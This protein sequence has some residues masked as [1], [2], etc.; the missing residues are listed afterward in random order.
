MTSLE[1]PTV[2]A[3]DADA[4]AALLVEHYDLRGTLSPLPGERDQNFRVVDAAGQGWVAKVALPDEESAFVMQAALLAHVAAVDPTL[5]IPRLRPSQHGQAI[6]PIAH[7]GRSYRLRVVSWLEGT[8]L[9]ESPRSH[10]QLRA[11]GRTA[12]RLA[13][14][15]RSFGHP[16]AHR[17]LDWDIARTLLSRPR[18]AHVEDPDRRA[19]LARALDDFEVRVTPRLPALRHSVVH[20][21]LNDWNVLV[22]GGDSDR[23]S[24]LIDLGDTVFS[25]TAADVAIACAYAMLDVPSPLIAAREVIGGFHDRMPLEE[26][27]LE[28]MLDLI[29][30][31]LATSLC[32]SATRRVLAS[33]GNSYWF[34]SERPAWTL[35][36]RLDR[37]NRHH[38]L[39]L[40]RHACGLEPAR[41]SAAIQRWIARSTARFA[42]ILD[43]PL[44]RRAT[45]RLDWSDPTDPVVA[46]TVRGDTA[47]ADAAYNAAA[48][49]GGF[50]VGVGAWC[51]ERA[52]Y[53]ADAFASKLIEGA[54]RTLHLGLDVFVDAGANLRTPLDGRV[55]VAADC[56][57][58]QD[59]GG[60]LLLEHVTDDGATFRTLWGHLAP[61]SIAHWKPGDVV[62]AG[63]VVARLGAS[64]ENGGWV[65]HLHL[66]L[67]CSGEHEAEAIIGVG[68]PEL[69]A[70]WESLYP[71]PTGLAGLPPEALATHVP[72]TQS[73]LERRRSH[74]GANLSL[75]YRRPLHI[76]RGTDVW[77]VDA[78]GRHYLDGYNNV[79]HVGHC[80]PRVVD[81]VARQAAQ[82]NTNTRYLHEHILTYA[83]RIA[84]TLPAPLGVC[85]FTCSGSEANELALRLARAHTR[86]RDVLV[87]DWAYHGSTTSLVEI[88]PYKYKHRGGEGRAA[89]VHEVPVPDPYRA[90]AD[91]PVEEI[92]T[93]YAQSVQATLSGGVAPAAFFAETIPSCAGQVFIPPGFLAE[94]YAAVRATGGVC[95]ADEV[96]VGFGRVGESMWAFAE[97]GVVPDIVTLGKPI[98]NGHPMG[99]VVTTPDIA[100]SFANG[101]EYFNTFG[102]NPVSC[103]AG[104]AVLDV[105]HDQALLP[106]AKKQGQ[107]I[108]AGLHDLMHRHEVIGDVRGRGLFIGVELVTDRTSKAPATRVAADVVNR[109]RDLGVLLGTDGPHDNVLKIRPPMTV[110]G[111][112]VQ[113]LL[114]TLG[115][116]LAAAG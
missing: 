62:R 50:D 63:D 27:E 32:M 79:A 18:L 9:A 34:V 54:R 20:G 70:L 93:R 106:N 53:S 90:P 45:Q 40:F 49:A 83:E 105:L 58:P 97:H 25:I 42:P 65:P 110:D 1:A 39:A 82:L 41:G 52:I 115:A 109:C 101:L 99:A 60:V 77:L 33:E 91:W 48:A 111:A 98:G 35:L 107:A 10:E 2:P 47:A 76:V 108:L 71:D 23:V 96:Q 114:H 59:Y 72:S 43:V 46:A 38:A 16:G 55:L 89:H 113:L 15:L 31:R 104:L 28:V 36:E 29:R 30:G 86:R 102:G 61:G 26:A 7:D 6:V 69:R 11:V 112:H 92:G 116:A 66:Q 37:V 4:V 74:L 68:E 8:P 87:L 56:N 14:A 17:A 5:A 75:A 22:D 88:S 67:C 44:A 21:D 81:A 95:V 78:R 80:H 100:A 12:G 19:R 103:A 73:L 85:F 24:G 57:R 3:L 13:R 64:H 94:A 84:S 51:E